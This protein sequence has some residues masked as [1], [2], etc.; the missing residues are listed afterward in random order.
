MEI[1]RNKDDIYMHLGSQ[2][3]DILVHNSLPLP[4]NAACAVPSIHVILVD[5]RE[6]TLPVEYC[7][8][9]NS[10]RVSSNP[11]WFLTGRGGG[12]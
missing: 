12:A 4:R 11:R 7:H 2:P 5:N 8:T 10:G 9:M 1:L 3:Y 6:H